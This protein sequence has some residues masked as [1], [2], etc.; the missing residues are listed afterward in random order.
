MENIQGLSVWLVGDWEIELHLERYNSKCEGYIL[1]FDDRRGL[2]S[3]QVLVDV[4]NCSWQVLWQALEHIAVSVLE[5]S[6][7]RLVERQCYS[8]VHYK[9]QKQQCNVQ[10]P[11][12]LDTQRRAFITKNRRLLIAY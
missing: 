7:E 12:K 3:F 11:F 5:L 9:K 6:D 4:I 10:Y 1:Y 8:V 2:S